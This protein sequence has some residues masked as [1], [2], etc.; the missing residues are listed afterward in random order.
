VVTLAVVALTL[1]SYPLGL[2]LGVPWLLPVL[3]TAP[4]YAALVHLLS[5]E[6]R[7]V[8][9]R[10]MLVWAVALAVGATVTFA[11]W[12]K[13]VDAMV[14]NGPAY[15]DQMFAWIRSGT[16]AEGDIR[17]FLPEHLFHLGAFVLLSL[18][19]ASALSMTM[20][21]VLMNYMGFYVASLARAGVPAGTVLFFGWQPWALCRV[22]A[23]CTLGV[24]LAE[25]LL[26]RLRG[27]PFA[28][29]SVWR[30]PLACAVAGILADWIL[31]ATLAPTWGRVLRS[32][33]P[34]VG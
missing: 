22:A 14:L 24:I 12:P 16:G 9:L 15:R 1:V 8:A 26:A 18:A 19:T 17:G 25:P 20:G 28:G 7:S 5:R 6:K 21:A 27:K 31:K 13:A 34:G 29:W 30:V 23:F 4:A 33:F 11:A 10:L 3:N 2:A 32:A